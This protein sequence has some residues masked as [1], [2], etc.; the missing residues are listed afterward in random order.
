MKA[1]QVR[2]IESPAN[3]QF[4][5]WKKCLEPQGIKKHGQFLLSGRKLV[6]EFLNSHPQQVEALI[7]ANGHNEMSSEMSAHV[8]T[9][10]LKKSLFKELDVIGT[11]FPLLLMTA[12]EFE[13]WKQASECKGVEVLLA[14]QDPGNLGAAIRLCEAFDVTKV[15][16][17]KESAHPL[18]PRAIKSSAGSVLRVP[19]ELGPSIQEL[20]PDFVYALDANGTSVDRFQWPR[21]LRLLLGEEGQ[22]IPDHLKSE[23]N[24]LSI[25]MKKTLE[26]L[27]ATSSLAIALYANSIKSR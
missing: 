5:T 14:L 22:G 1:N 21:N 24:L 11:D 27:N 25:P 12:P 4:K 26:S 7:T 18:H 3:P 23:K 20:S 17:L 9:Y 8:P 10:Q 15:I 13:T 6:G 16:C 2:V 19:I